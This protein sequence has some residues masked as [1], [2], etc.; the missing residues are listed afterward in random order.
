MSVFQDF[1]KTLT[2]GKTRLGQGIGAGS[3]G[4]F[5]ANGWKN[6][7]KNIRRKVL[8]GAEIFTTS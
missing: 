3:V 5:L 6:R 2:S 4:T 8:V 1:K 7:N